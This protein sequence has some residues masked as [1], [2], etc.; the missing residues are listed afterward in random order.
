MRRRG[1]AETV[2]GNIDV[3]R[4]GRSYVLDVSYT[5]QSPGLARDIAAGIADV[6]LVDKLNSK[7]EATRRAGQYTYPNSRPDP[8]RQF[9]VIRR[10]QLAKDAFLEEAL[11]STQ[12]DGTVGIFVH[13]YNYSY[14]EAL[15]R[16]AQIA[17]DAN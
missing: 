10:K 16:T 11:R 4:V 9:A 6:Y 13:G 8:E 14:Q 7:Y 12:S 17:A 3:E 1:A 5:A 15:F 2:A